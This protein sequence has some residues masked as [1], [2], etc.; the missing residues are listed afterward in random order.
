M[1]CAHKLHRPVTEHFEHVDK[2]E[3]SDRV[4][5]ACDIGPQEVFPGQSIISVPCAAPNGA[6]STLD[7]AKRR[8]YTSDRLGRQPF[9]LIMRSHVIQFLAGDIACGG[10]DQVSSTDRK[11]IHLV[12]RISVHFLRE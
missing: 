6:V 11:H 2:P 3:T 8:G 9:M 7:Q 12:E 5:S 1:E 4:H 10:L